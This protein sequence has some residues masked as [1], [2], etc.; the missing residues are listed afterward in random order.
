MAPAQAETAL[1]V[2]ATVPEAPKPEEQPKAKT[3]EELQASVDRLERAV[4][5]AN[6]EAAS[7]RVRL[8]ELER[9]DQE[10]QK[11]SLSEVDR[12][13]QQVAEAQSEAEKA[14]SEAATVRVKTA[15]IVA[16]GQM[17]FQDP[18]DA[19]A[20][21]DLSKLEIEKDGKVA[22][23]D[24]ALKALVKAKAYMIKKTGAGPIGPT[25]PSGDKGAKESDAE[26]RKR[27]LG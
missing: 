27:L 25:N 22:G 5:D 10:R 21:L 7:K 4:K 1:P 19:Y 26:R 15:V 9:A 6:K 17:G 8:E 3:A 16:A 24:E 18:E 11:A 20:L 14:R 23:V 2:I 13:K 12:L